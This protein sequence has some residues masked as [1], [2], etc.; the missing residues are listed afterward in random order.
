MASIPKGPVPLSRVTTGALLIAAVI[1][2]AVALTVVFAL[3]Y[4][5]S[6]WQRDLRNWQVRLGIV[7]DSR[8]AAIDSWLEE[9]VHSLSTLAENPSLQLYATQIALAPTD[10]ESQSIIDAQTEYVRNLLEA[11]AL[12][13]GFAGGATAKVKASLPSS[14]T[15]GLA[16]LDSKGQLVVG[17]S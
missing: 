12:Q 11:S 8:F 9:Q 13:G 15:A 10:E 3:S 2:G 7:A 1:V 4:V 6:E 17:S 14:G 16:L 5:E